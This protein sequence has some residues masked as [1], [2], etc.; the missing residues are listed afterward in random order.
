[1]LKKISAGFVHCLL[2]SPLYISPCLE[3]CSDGLQDGC[4]YGCSNSSLI[5]QYFQYSHL[6]GRDGCSN[7]FLKDSPTT[8][9][10]SNRRCQ[11]GDSCP[12]STGN[13]GNA[14]D[15]GD[16]SAGSDMLVEETCEN[17]EIASTAVQS[18]VEDEDA[19]SS[20]VDIFGA[21]CWVSESASFDEHYQPR[22]LDWFE[23][24]EHCCQTSSSLQ[25]SIGLQL[26][27]QG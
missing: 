6:I 22:A 4:R 25:K 10:D 9:S 11:A 27:I 16:N 15:L 2:Y 24:T 5:G 12:G 26:G 23:N 18:D 7:S 13:T 21:G 17:G 1:M 14:W 19:V 3:L 8:D 20:V